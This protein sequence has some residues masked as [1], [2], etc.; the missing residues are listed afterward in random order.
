MTPDVTVVIPCYNGG[1]TIEAAIESLRKQTYPLAEIIVVDDGSTDPQTIAILDA[2]DDIRLIRQHNAGLARA[3]NVGFR[4][5]R[6]PFILP[7]DADDWLAPN[8]IA[9]LRAQLD[10]TPT[11]AFAFGWIR[12]EQEAQGVL[13]KNYNHFEQ[14][15]FNQIP[16]CM[17]F[18]R[19]DWI[20][21]GGYWEGMEAQ[22][23]EDWEL[24]I[25]LGVDGRFGAVVPEPLFHYRVTSG[26]MLLTISR[27]KHIRLWRQIRRRH[28]QAYGLR[29]LVAEW[30]RWRGR[31]STYPVPLLIAWLALDR[32]L[33]EAIT[34][35]LFKV[36]LRYAHSRRLRE[37]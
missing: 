8:A 22:G 34:Q 2:L 7:L 1:A 30:R 4:A 26:G 12:L 5:A 16:Y 19:D 29:Q 37:P 35:A 15:F 36:G 23:Y 20:R 28:K 11:A 18:R 31:S 21:A 24:N 32:A 17:L 6:T 14:L 9:R 25:R 13:Q 3:R 33:P 27:R 10:Q